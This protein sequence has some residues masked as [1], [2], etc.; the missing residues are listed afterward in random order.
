MCL[1][2]MCNERS[3]AAGNRS[4]DP[5]RFSARASGAAS[6]DLYLSAQEA[7]SALGV[8]VATLYCYVS[9]GYVRTYKTPG[10]RA[11]RYWRSDIDQIKQRRSLPARS[12]HSA[13]GLNSSITLITNNEVFYH[14]LNVVEL[15][16]SLSFEAVTALLWQ[17]PEA[18]V[19]GDNLPEPSAKQSAVMD[20]LGQCG[21]VERIM[22]LAPLMERANPRCYD[23]SARSFYH[24]AAAA[25]RWLTAIVVDA[26]R[27]TAAPIHMMLARTEDE[28][29]PVADIVRRLLVL[30]A[31]HDLDPTT[32]AVRAVANTG[33]SPY[34]VIMTGLIAS[35]GHRGPIGASVAVA[36][37]LNEALHSA[38]PAAPFL[39][40]LRNGEALPGFGSGH[41]AGT[42]PRT[43]ALLQVLEQTLGDRPMVAKFLRLVAIAN[44]ATGLRP[45][46]GMMHLIIGRVIGLSGCDVDGLRLSRVAGWMAHAVEQY[47]EHALIRPRANYRGRLPG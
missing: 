27:P 47:S 26:D 45:S 44:D 46:F 22:L 5:Q 35:G 11:S 24:S 40:R 17:M 4:S 42:D 19:F 41:Y 9:R 25:L 32:L 16:K 37:L 23:L 15:A 36:R 29:D 2:S 31:D 10:Q 12:Q 7:A 39:E 14:G 43:E 3:P 21:L 6:E 33:V 20:A 38:D 1:S 30:S 13:I 8:S 18:D 28:A 34:R